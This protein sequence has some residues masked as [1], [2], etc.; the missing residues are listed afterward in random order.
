MA[1]LPGAV[2]LGWQ[3]Q[4]AAQVGSNPEFSLSIEAQRREGKEGA[5]PDPVCPQGAQSHGETAG[6]DQEPPQPGGREGPQSRQ[7]L[8]LGTRQGVVGRRAPGGH[9]RGLV[10]DPLTSWAGA[11]S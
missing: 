1:V 2:E 10:C 9:R 6:V 11:P 7:P 3:R 5:S 4:V 8:A